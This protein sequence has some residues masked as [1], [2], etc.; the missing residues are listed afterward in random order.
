MKMAEKP[1]EEER[2]M[3]NVLDLTDLV[4]EL[5]TI[6]WD[7]GRKDINPQ[8][9]LFAEKYLE[10]YDKISL[11]EVF[12]KHSYKH[13]D[14]IKD[15]NET[16]FV[17]NASEIFQYLPV[18]SKNINALRLFFTATTDDGE[19][20][21]VQD[22]RDAIWNIFDSLVRICIKYVHKARGFKLV[23]TP[24]GLRPAYKTRKFP[25]I[26]VRELARQWEITL[27]IPGKD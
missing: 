1:S 10:S 14:Q 8:M 13:W 19:H 2:F 21:I 12:I 23:K 20:I 9:V 16:F 18:D 26:K 17:E 5:A 3:T 15:R 4:H 22:D 27:P 25:D 24:K 11:I 6:C 7:A